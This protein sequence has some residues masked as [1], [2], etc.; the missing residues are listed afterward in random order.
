MSTVEYNSIEGGGVHVPS[1]SPLGG[2]SHHPEPLHRIQKVRSQQGV[3]PRSV[4]RKLGLTMQEVRSQEQPDADL[5]ISQLRAWQSILE[6]PMV[7]LLVDNDSTLSEPVA[8]RARLLR[9]MKTAKAIQEATTEA[10]IG[11]MSTMLI[12]Q[13]ID[14]MPEL[15]DVSAWHSVG[16]RRTQDEMGRIAEQV[17]PDSFFGDSQYS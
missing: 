7:D 12:E 1:T 9:A 5:K 6:V 2:A 17:I 16:Q 14:V 4:A 11:R 13:L 8:L 15:A 3:S 10:G